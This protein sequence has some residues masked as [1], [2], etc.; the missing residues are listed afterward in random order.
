MSG[1]T[2]NVERDFSNCIYQRYGINSDEAADKL[3]QEDTFEN[4]GL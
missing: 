1:L 3:K 4:G 2:L